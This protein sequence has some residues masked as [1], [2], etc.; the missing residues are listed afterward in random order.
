MKPPKVAIMITSCDAY[1]DCWRPIIY[2]LD[3]YWPDCE[4]PRYIVTNYKD[5]NLPNT[6]FVKIG[7]DHRSWCNLARMGMEA[8]PEEYVIYFQDD[9]W[10]NMRV[11]N[12]AIKKHVQYFEENNLDFLKIYDDM[13]RDNHR[14]GNSDYCWNNP[15]IRYSINTA[16]A[17]WRKSTISKLMIQDWDGWQFERQIIPY[18]A[19]H[20]IQIKS[21]TLHSS[22]VAEKGINTIPGNAIVRGVWTYSAVDFLKENG[23]EDVLAKRV[24][25]GPLTTWLYDHSPSPQSIMRYPFWGALKILKKIKVNW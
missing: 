24:V 9:Y 6:K 23:M 7:D 8:I 22:V 5:E 18:I 12:E 25:M 10:L 15:D 11:D 20:H 17:I 14:I 4:F 21:Q 19:E 13:P 2:S 3:K 16:I 1:Q